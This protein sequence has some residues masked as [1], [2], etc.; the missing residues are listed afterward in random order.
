MTDDFGA[1]GGALGPKA[2]WRPWKRQHRSHRPGGVTHLAGSP[3]AAAGDRQNF[4][5]RSIR[6]A[7]AA[8]GGNKL[9]AARF[10]A[11]RATLYEKLSALAIESTG[12]GGDEERG[13]P[14]RRPAARSAGGH[15]RANVAERAALPGSGGAARATAP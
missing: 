8:T 2:A 10:S 4:E 13:V 3:A 5:E 7:L 14:N 9:A 6:D 1:D 11:S 15:R 12:P